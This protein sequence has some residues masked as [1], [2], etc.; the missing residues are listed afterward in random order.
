M[1]AMN[2]NIGILHFVGIGGIG[3]SGI[4]EIL[5]S[6][7]YQV[8]GSDLSENAN[9]TRLREKGVQVFIGH[10]GKHVEGVSAVV[11]SSAVP[12]DNAEIMAARQMSIPVVRRA[13]MLAELMRLKSAI[14]VGG[15]HGKTTTTAMIGRMLEIAGLDP[16]VIN[17][18]I[19]N[20]YGSNTRLGQSD[21]MVVEADESD[22]TFTRLPASVTVVTNIDPE[23]MDHYGSFDGVR[24]AYRCFVQNIPFYGYAVL[25]ADHPEVQALAARI[26]DRRVVTYG[27]SPQADICAKN[28]RMSPE[29]ARFDVSFAPWLF[30]DGQARA[31]ANLSMPMLGQHNVQ[32]AL[33]A[34]AVAQQSGI[35]EATMR[36]GLSEFSGVKRR[37]TPTGLVGGVQVID[38]YAHHP[39]EIATVLKTARVVA[40]NN[41]GRVVAVMQPHRYS[42][43]SELFEDF[44]TCFNDAE[45]VILAPVYAAGETPVD[46][47]DH[48][49]LAEKM[50]AYGHRRV[51]VIERDEELAPLLAPMVQSGDYVVCMGAGDITRWAYALPDQLEALLKVQAA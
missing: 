37:F 49:A 44:C 39:V 32:N 10:E 34:L 48:Y 22:G 42:R 51:M 12:A 50:R 7:G 9:V 38:D 1:R 33:A 6:L 23:H 15:T 36:K 18:G 13:E 46:G 11:I 5:L 25:C 27:F 20:A 35:D 14:A 3:M 4:A 41:H 19:V 43:L 30:D 26:S 2:E 8:Q 47:A 21:L 40:E 24:D 29:G 16:T 31:M 45:T 28:V 17:G